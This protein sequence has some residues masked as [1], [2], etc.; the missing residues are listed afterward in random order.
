[1]RKSLQQATWMSAVNPCQCAYFK[2]CNGQCFLTSCTLKFDAGSDCGGGAIFNNNAFSCSDTDFTANSA[3]R[4]SLGGGAIFNAD[5]F[6]GSGLNFTSNNA[7]IKGGTVYAPSP[8]STLW[9]SAVIIRESVSSEDGAVSAG[10]VTVISSSYFLNNTGLKGGGLYLPTEARVVVLETSFSANDA[11]TTGGAVYVDTGVNATFRNCT[12]ENNTSP[13]GGAVSLATLDSTHNVT[14]SGST[15]TNN[16]ASVGAGGAIIQ[17]GI[18]LSVRVDSTNTFID[19]AAQCCYAGWNETQGGD[20]CVDTSYGYSTG[21]SCCSAAQYLSADIAEPACVYCNAD[22]LQ[23]AIIGITVQT[24]PLAAGCW[25]ETFSEEVIRECWNAGACSGGSADGGTSTDLYCHPGYEGPY[26]AVC[27]DG[28]ASLPGYRCVECTPK[29][30]ATTFTILAISI[31]AI[32]C[33]VWMLL[34]AATGVG[35]GVGSAQAVGSAG[36]ALKVTRIALLLMQRLR[37]PIVVLQVLTQY[38]SI[39]GISLPLQYL[40]FLRAIDFLSLDLRWLTS[41]GCAVHLDFYGRLLLTTLAPLVATAL[42]FL[43]RLYVWTMS[44]RGRTCPKLRQLIAK[45]VNVFLV[46]TFLIFSGVSLRVFETFGCDGSLSRSYLRAD[47]SLECGTSRHTAFSVYAGVMVLV[48][49]VGIPLLYAAV[50]RH[51]AVTHRAG[52]QASRYATAASFLWR[53]YRGR[54]YYWECAECFRR[55][56]L[57]GFLVFIL[58]GTAGQSAVA[59][60]FAVFTGMVYEQIRPHQEPMDKWLYTLGYGII[61]ASMFTSLLMQANYIDGSSEQAIGRLLIA[62]NVLLLAMALTQMAL[63]YRSVRDA[64]RPIRQNSF[65]GLSHAAS[66]PKAAAAQSFS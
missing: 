25:R 51:S 5:T 13:V 62:L 14:I 38:V 42:I 56:I 54:A 40:R 27:S 44:R 64:D 29:A 55:L 17:Q 39:T 43:P 2:L 21:W 36:A 46:F 47:Y 7:A 19:N 49:P 23:C 30:T 22:E 48:Y 50:L 45:D 66:S 8:R 59:C 65:F 3:L 37:I 24:L 61:F 12:F 16:S 10:S 18:S 34:S 41:P 52:G 60:V 31:V 28:Y 20:S 33:I 4:D 32:L 63:V 57:A 35:D 15:F 6:T 9:L 26:C 53:P 11:T 1:M 58:P